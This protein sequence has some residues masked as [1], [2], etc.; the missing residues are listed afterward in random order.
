MI[1]P[2]LHNTNHSGEGRNVHASH[3]RGASA[4]TERGKDAE[5]ATGL[6]ALAPYVLSAEILGLFLPPQVP[7][8]VAGSNGQNSRPGYHSNYGDRD[9]K[10]MTHTNE[11]TMTMTMHANKGMGDDVEDDEQTFS[12]LWISDVAAGRFKTDFSETNARASQTNEQLALLA[13]STIL[14]GK[15]RTTVVATTEV[16]DP[17][18]REGGG[19]GGRV[20]LPSAR[21][22]GEPEANSRIFNTRSQ[23]FHETFKAA[24]GWTAQAMTGLQVGKREGAEVDVLFLGI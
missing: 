17:S 1:A 18:G 21:E 15:T 12:R 4:G 13:A 24:H 16:T 23:I 19:G 3:S 22:E 2:S 14:A 8:I 20:G 10:E 5:K 9:K 7:F 6:Q 11:M